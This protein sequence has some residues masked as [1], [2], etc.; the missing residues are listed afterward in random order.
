MKINYA[1]GDGLTTVDRLVD[2]YLDGDGGAGVREPRRPLPESP[3]GEDAL[4][5]EQ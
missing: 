3:G 1:Y 2:D 4:D 5:P